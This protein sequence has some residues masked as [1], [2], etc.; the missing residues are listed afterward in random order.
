MKTNKMKIFC[1]YCK[2]I[3]RKRLEYIPPSCILCPR[4]GGAVKK[5]VN[6]NLPKNEYNNWLHVICS[7]YNKEI[8]LNRNVIKINLF[9]IMKGLTQ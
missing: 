9:R 4:R 5:C 8:S 2:Y 7:H 6:N 3:E 1:D